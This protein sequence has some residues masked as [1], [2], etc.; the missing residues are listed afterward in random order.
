V[1]GA[2]E[3]IDLLRIVLPPEN[4]AIADDLEVLFRFPGWKNSG[5]RFSG[6]SS[7]SGQRV[8][9]GDVA[10]SGNGP[11]EPSTTYRSRTSRT[12]KDSVAVV[13][14]ETRSEARGGAG[15]VL[16]KRRY[17]SILSLPDVADFQE[18]NVSSSEIPAERKFVSGPWRSLPRV[19]LARL[20]DVREFAGHFRES[21]NP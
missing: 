7:S 16:E 12:G 2:K 5:S 10:A 19:A 21:G 6:T 14:L 3:V 4:K 9:V 18:E 17:A 8:K 15:G 1:N 20:K 13:P 11:I